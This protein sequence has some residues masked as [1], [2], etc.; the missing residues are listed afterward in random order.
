MIES[1]TEKELRVEPG[2][3]VTPR[4]SGSLIAHWVG[5]VTRM[6]PT[7][8]L[9]CY[10]SWPQRAD[11][12][13]EMSHCQKSTPLEL[14]GEVGE[15]K[16]LEPEGEMRHLYSPDKYKEYPWFSLRHAGHLTYKEYLKVLEMLERT[17][18]S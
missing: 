2:A 16:A 6:H 8:P 13:D 11:L 3:L 12:K 9:L 7:N 14:V 18:N 4:Y 15:Y 17:Q 5:V 1:L 10:V